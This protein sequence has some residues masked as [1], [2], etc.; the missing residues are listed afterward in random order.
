MRCWGAMQEKYFEETLLGVRMNRIDSVC[1]YCSAP[2]LENT[3][4]IW[5]ICLVSERTIYRLLLPP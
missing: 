1:Y 3:R 5:R 4:L 2:N